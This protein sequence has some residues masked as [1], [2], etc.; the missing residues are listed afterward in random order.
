MEC[1]MGM[2]YGSP[3]QW[4]NLIDMK[5]RM[6]MIENADMESF[7]GAMEHYIKEIILMILDKDM[8]RCIKIM[9]LFI[10]ENG[11]EECKQ[12]T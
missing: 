10:K 1:V 6:L 4:G 2:V 11:I 7:H 9:W 5:E 12:T 8:A 3:I